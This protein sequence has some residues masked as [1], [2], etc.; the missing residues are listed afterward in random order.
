MKDFIKDKRGN[1]VYFRDLNQQTKKT[2]KQNAKDES[3]LFLVFGLLF[4]FIVSFV[5]SYALLTSNFFASFVISS[6]IC[7][8]ILP[9]FNIK[10]NNL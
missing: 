5:F 1:L 3:P 2:S 8:L 4:F 9:I 7:L 10:S 6:F